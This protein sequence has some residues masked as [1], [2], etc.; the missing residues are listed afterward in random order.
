[1]LHEVYDACS[2]VKTKI[3]TNLVMIASINI[4]NKEIEFVDNMYIRIPRSHQN[5]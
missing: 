3:V 4:V 1:M 5:M 2:A